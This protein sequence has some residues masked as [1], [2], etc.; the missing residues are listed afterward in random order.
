[1]PRPLIAR[2]RR[3]TRPFD[4]KHHPR[5]FDEQRTGKSG[6][7][8]LAEVPELPQKDGVRFFSYELSDDI[9]VAIE[10]DSAVPVRSLILCHCVSELMH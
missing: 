4:K 1:M 3:P 9:D 2:Q 7:M 10:H 5:W 8:L 6:Q